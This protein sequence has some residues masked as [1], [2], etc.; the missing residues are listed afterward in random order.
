MNFGF[1][2]VGLVNSGGGVAPE[3]GAT[4]FIPTI[5]LRCF[6]LFEQRQN[7]LEKKNHFRWPNFQK[8]KTW[9][10][11]CFEN[12][13]IKDIL[14]ERRWQALKGKDYSTEMKN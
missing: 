13:V 9:Q 6:P 12:L 3:S 11:Y 5:S 8:T 4:F 7:R 2:A 1:G 10:N 14:P